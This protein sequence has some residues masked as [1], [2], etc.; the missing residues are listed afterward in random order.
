MAAALILAIPAAEIFRLGRI[1]PA[2]TCVLFCLAQR[3]RW[4]AAMRLRAEGYIVRA[5]AALGVLPFSKVRAWIAWS[6]RVRSS[7]NSLMIPPKFGIDEISALQ[8]VKA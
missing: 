1:A 5:G 6:M 2:L 4:A 3:A 7:G 8:N